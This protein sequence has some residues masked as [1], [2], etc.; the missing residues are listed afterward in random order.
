[1]GE[2]CVV[3]GE[4]IVSSILSNTLVDRYAITREHRAKLPLFAPGI[5]QA[6]V[7]TASA[8]LDNYH[9]LGPVA[10]SWDDTALEPAL[11]A[12]KDSDGTWLILGGTEG[13]ISVS[14][15]EELEAIFAKGNMKPGDKVCH[16]ISSLFLALCLPLHL[17]KLRLYVLTIPLAKIPPIIL[18]AVVRG[19]SERATDLKVMHDQVITLLHNA[20]IY[21]VSLSSD[22]SEVERSVQR[23][24]HQSAPDL[25]RYT[26]VHELPNCTVNLEIPLIYDHPSVIVQDSKH[27]LKT[28]RNQTLTG[29]R[30][31][32]LGNY[33]IHFAQLQDMAQNP[34]S[35]LQSR[36]IINVDKQHDGAAAR[37][38]SAEALDFHL[39]NYSEQRGLA[40][41]LFVIG[42]LVDAWQSRNIPH[43]ERVRMV[44]RARYF[45]MAWRTHIARHP[46]H[47][48]NTQF[49]SRS[50]YDIFLTLSDSL[51]S[52]I[53]TYRKFY[54]TY[55]LLPWL[56]S[57]EPCEHLF[58]LIRQIKP[59]FSYT[60]FLYLQPKLRALLLGAFGDLSAEQQANETASGYH[61]TYF[62]AD[63]LD[64]RSLM[65]YPDDEQLH[66]ILKYAVEDVIALLAPL[67]IDGK[68]MLSTYIPPPSYLPVP[69][70]CSS[71][72]SV[73]HPNRQPRNLYELLFL[74]QNASVPVVVEERVA[75]VELAL[76]A[77]SI[78]ATAKM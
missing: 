8:T 18:A 68:S 34:A 29:A 14:S 75:T 46:D 64:L 35:P 42:E 38:F 27:A 60:D 37:L 10:L 19:G 2:A 77:E 36:D 17:F 76:A 40:T 72:S 45:L 41:Y 48:V 49:I 21:P 74:Y 22:G 51:I 15:H 78:D 12:Y 9:Y 26:I 56:H 69:I 47:D 66:S 50:S 25:L 59:D 70:P 30:I 43:I 54:S 53:I 44:L 1:M 73:V 33:T 24:I 5:S 63:D 39:T 62:K 61:H 65:D 58:G 13:P 28:A 16:I 57:S 67:G 31:L 52:L 71:S 7:D 11:Q 32:V 20:H 4:L 6:N 3:F 55:P 23:M